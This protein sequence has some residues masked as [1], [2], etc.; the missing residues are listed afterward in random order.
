MH[1]TLEETTAKRE[2]LKTVNLPMFV[3]VDG[4]SIIRNSR[5][6]LCL[7]EHLDSV[8]LRCRACKGCIACSADPPL[9]LAC[10]M[11]DYCGPWHRVHRD[12]A[13]NPKKRVKKYE[14][15]KRFVVPIVLCCASSGP[16]GERCL[17]CMANKPKFDYARPD[18]TGHFHFRRKVLTGK[19]AGQWTGCPYGAVV[20][21]GISTSTPLT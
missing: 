16:V 2:Q 11:D 8:F 14:G 21:A 20:D 18:S 1:S 13:L 4:D 17:K 15:P 3:G 7:K 12:A 9:Y 6:C 5:V 10:V 19:K